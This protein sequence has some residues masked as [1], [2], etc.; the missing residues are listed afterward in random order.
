[1]P[2]DD[3]YGAAKRA[4]VRSAVEKADWESRNRNFYSDDGGGESGAVVSNEVARTDQDMM[5]IQARRAM[6]KKSNKRNSRR[7]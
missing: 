5:R 1:M 4:R 7:R 3:E 2:N 6:A